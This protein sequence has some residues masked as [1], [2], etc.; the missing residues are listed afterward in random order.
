MS[1]SAYHLTYPSASQLQV[2]VP[3]G[4]LFSS[5]LICAILA[6]LLLVFIPC[7][8]TPVRMYKRQPLTFPNKT[9]PQVKEFA[10]KLFFGM[11][12]GSIL[13][14]AF[15][16][17]ASYSSGSIVLDGTNDTASMTAKM[18]LFLPGKTVSRNLHDVDRAVLDSAPNSRRIRLVTKDGAD[19]AYPMWSNRHGQDEAV[20][21]INRFLNH[22]R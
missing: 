22:A 9:L 2:V 6:I 21:A 7:A 14:L 1:A 3:G 15:I 10:L 18:T 11:T 17:A 12:A 5:W 8:L 16:W 20:N 4:S 19:L 13:L